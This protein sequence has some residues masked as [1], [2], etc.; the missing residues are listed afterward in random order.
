[1]VH[2]YIFTSFRGPDPDPD[3]DRI[4]PDW[5][6]FKGHYLDMTRFV[7]SAQIRIR[8]TAFYNCLQR[9]EVWC[10]DIG[11]LVCQIMHCEVRNHDSRYRNRNNV[12]NILEVI[13]EKLRVESCDI[14]FA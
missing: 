1:L 8:N 10:F 13:G 4:G 2:E 7:K 3:P 11:L 12:K 14:V 9:L 6:I 5:V